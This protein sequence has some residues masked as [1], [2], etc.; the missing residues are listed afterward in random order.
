MPSL[1]QLLLIYYLAFDFFHVKLMIYPFSFFSWSLLFLTVYFI[2]RIFRFPRL[3]PF[4]RE[5]T[6]EEKG[7]FRL[8]L[9]WMDGWMDVLLLLLGL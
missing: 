1:A 4:G 5:R 7:K 3:S 2:L 6:R 8:P 9:G